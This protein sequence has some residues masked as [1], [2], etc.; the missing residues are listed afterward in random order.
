MQTALVSIIPIYQRNGF[1]V[2]FLMSVLSASKECHQ[3]IQDSSIHIQTLKYLLISVKD[4][5]YESIYYLRILSNCV[6]NETVLMAKDLIQDYNYLFKECLK[7]L[8][9]SNINVLKKECIGL[10]GNLL[11]HPLPLVT[12]FGLE[13]LE[14]NYNSVKH[15]F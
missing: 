15:F 1:L 14:E 13:I 10:V 3:I 12:A 6:S 8:L 9:Q 7:L 2:V 4:S 11:N 5:E